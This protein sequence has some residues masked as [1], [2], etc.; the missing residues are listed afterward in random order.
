[1]AG[2]G[3][4]DKLTLKWLKV[5]ATFIPFIRYNFSQ[6]LLIYLHLPLYH[7]ITR[8]RVPRVLPVGIN[9]ETMVL[10]YDKQQLAYICGSDKA[11]ASQVIRFATFPDI[12]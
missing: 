5:I 4:C 11:T 3:I 2:F 1:V 8:S 9:E 7:L 6:L 10:F 12:S